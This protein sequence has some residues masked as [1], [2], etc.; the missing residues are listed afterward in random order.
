M[1]ANSLPC[2]IHALIFHDFYTL[3]LLLSTV[4]QNDGKL[5]WLLC[6]NKC[7]VF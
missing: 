7:L 6:I 3:K 1:S 4:K 5:S 2:F